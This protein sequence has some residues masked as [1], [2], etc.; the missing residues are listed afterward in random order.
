MK[1][2]FYDII[3][4]LGY[5][6]AKMYLSNNKNY[7]ECRNMLYNNRNVQ[8]YN[9]NEDNKKIKISKLKKIVRRC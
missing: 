6:T 9:Y 2:A 8:H 3:K 7:F 1:I 4:Y 5:T